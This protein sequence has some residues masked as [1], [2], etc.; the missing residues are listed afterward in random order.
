MRGGF[1]T[2]KEAEQALAE[3]ITRVGLGHVPAQGRQTLSEYLETWLVGCEMTLAATAFTNYRTVLRHYVLPRIGQYRLAKLTPGILTSLYAELLRTGSR[4]GGPLSPATVR[5]VHRVLSKA[6][7]DAVREQLLPTNPA[8]HAKLPRRQRPE[9]K[10]WTAE[11]A[12]AFLVHA[13]TDRLYAAW[14]LALAC[15]LRRGELAGL[16][17]SD[18][19]FDA[20]TVT[21]LNQRTVDA[22]WN[23]VVKE[24]KGTSRRTLDLGQGSVAALRQHRNQTNLER[25]AAGPAWQDSGLVFVDALGRPYHPDRLTRMFRQLSADAG[26]PLIRLHD[27]RHSC[28]T[29]ALAAGIHPK[30]VQQL[31]GHSSWS[32]T[33]DLYTHRIARLQREASSLIEALVLPGAPVGQSETG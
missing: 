22:E 1:G 27:A 16:R 23:V 29:L 15:G 14:L 10:T 33:M 20:A 12:S 30:V 7:G 5:T 4:R 18:V 8:T 2:K 31:L 25:L 21:I 13:R 6:L 9:M 28:A 24:P 17:W 3:F 32:T 26:V 19:D 11:Q